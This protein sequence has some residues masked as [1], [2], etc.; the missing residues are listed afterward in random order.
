MGRN[1]RPTTTQQKRRAIQTDKP[2]II[3]E[4]ELDFLVEIF[5]RGIA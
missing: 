4:S 3:Y 5:L 2:R 1:G